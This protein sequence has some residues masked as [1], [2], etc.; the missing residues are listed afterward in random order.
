M[1]ARMDRSEALR[2]AEVTAHAE[3]ARSDEVLAHALFQTLFE[4]SADGVMLTRTDG[5]ILRANP[6]ACAMLGRSEDE[7]RRAG[8]QQLV[9]SDARLADHLRQRESTGIAHGELLYRRLD[10]S[11]FPV[12]F[13]SVVLPMRGTERHTVTL[14]RD[15]TG[16][17]ATEE[18]QGRL[19]AI[20]ASS[21]D[22][23]V[24]KDLEGR[25]LSW[26][27]GAERLFGYVAAEM[28]GRSM[29]VLLPPDRIDE[30]AEIL[31]RVRAGER[32][33]PF[34]TVRL[35]KDGREVYVSVTASPVRD[36]EGRVIGVSKIGRDVTQRKLT[37]QALRESE[38]RLALALEGSNDGFW[39]LDLAGR[40]HTF[41]DR[42][43]DMIGEPQ[44]GPMSSARF[45]WERVH[46]DD[47]RDV[48]RAI[49]DHIRGDTERIYV[50]YRL[51]AR[52]GGWRWV[53]AAG[54]VVERDASGR[55]TRLAGTLRDVTQRR[56]AEDRLRTALA[57][58]EALV[59]Q[60]REA[61]QKV[62][63]LSGLIPVCAWCR[64]IRNDAGYWKKIEDYVAEHTDAIFTHGMCPECFASTGK[65]Q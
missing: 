21:D 59:L 60:L 61:L 17:K 20:V 62:R 11:T 34:E 10:G 47:E 57:E 29:T 25:V 22:A 58:N 65:D 56:E 41:S 33:E 64:R 51:R 45:W 52:G 49:H 48:R 32:V 37:E 55:A 7:I 5:S 30:E 28:I 9:V 19:A 23:I 24:S 42:V 43:F 16:R 53:R 44:Q 46:P 4:R 13:T 2:E 12:E 3:L 15:L 14:F 39:N 6:A 38:R 54:K 63:T 50:E 18:L 27:S 36:G 8:R 1:P 26:N 31:R 35:R 40:R